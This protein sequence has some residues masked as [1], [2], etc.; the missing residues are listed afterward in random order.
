MEKPRI[1]FAFHKNDS[2]WKR[3]Y[4]AVGQI[5]LDDVTHFENYDDFEDV[6][7]T[8]IEQEKIRLIMLKIKSFMC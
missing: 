5:W 1:P 8:V 7:E 3:P 4:K 2:E 6:L